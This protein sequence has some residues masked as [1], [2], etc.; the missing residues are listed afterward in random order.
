M[1]LS[2]NI[3]SGV[4]I[5][6]LDTPFRAGDR[7]DTLSDFHK[8]PNPYIGQIV[9]V[10]SEEKYYIITELGSKKV[11][12]ITFPDSIATSWT[13]VDLSGQTRSVSYA[14]VTKKPDTDGLVDFG[15]PAK[16]LVYKGQYEDRIYVGKDSY[17]SP[18]AA[19]EYLVQSYGSHIENTETP[20]GCTR[21]YITESYSQTTEMQYVGVGDNSGW[22]VTGSGISEIPEEYLDITTSPVYLGS[23]GE[24]LPS[25]NLQTDDTLEPVYDRVTTDFIPLGRY[26]SYWYSLYT[27]SSLY[28]VVIYDRDKN[29]VTN[30]KGDSSGIALK[31][32]H[33]TF[34]QQ[35]L[36]LLPERF[37]YVRFSWYQYKDLNTP[38]EHSIKLYTRSNLMGH[39][40]K[41]KESQRILSEIS[42]SHIDPE[43]ALWDT[44][45]LSPAAWKTTSD[46]PLIDKKAPYLVKATAG[47]V[48][49]VGQ[50]QKN[51]WF[52]YSDG[53][54]APTWITESPGSSWETEDLGYDIVVGWNEPLWYIGGVVGDS[55]K[56]I[57][58]FFGEPT[59]YDGVNTRKLPSSGISASAGLEIS[60]VLRS[61][62]F[63]S[64]ITGTSGGESGIAVYNS[65]GELVSQYKAPGSGSGVYWKLGGARADFDTEILGKNSSTSSVTPCSPVLM[66]TWMAHLYAAY[67]KYGTKGLGELFGTGNTGY[68]LS[69]STWGTRTGTR[70]RVSGEKDWTYTGNTFKEQYYYYPT[71]DSGSLEKVKSVAE[72]FTGSGYFRTLGCEQQMALSWA[73][74]NNIQSGV[75]F[76]FQG[77]TFW[78]KDI[79][80]Y[81]SLLEGPEMSAKL[82]KRYNSGAC[83]LLD[84]TGSE[85]ELEI[86]VVLEYPVVC[87]E[88]LGNG[89]APKYITGMEA[90]VEMSSIP[91]VSGSVYTNPASVYL[92]HTQEDLVIPGSYGSMTAGTKYEF[93]G[94]Y[95]KLGD[96]VFSGNAPTKT[97]LPYTCYQEE[98]GIS[99]TLSECTMFYAYCP[100][101]DTYGWGSSSAEIGTRKS[102]YP[103]IG[104]GGLGDTASWGTVDLRY[105]GSTTPEACAYFQVKFPDTKD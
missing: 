90:V 4:Q 6:S 20:L 66:T 48:Q 101:G 54:Y 24:E 68:E 3:S 31:T 10:L 21:R 19:Q 81:P 65:A 97:S 32:D 82:F 12:G 29:Y 16:D 70:Y 7:V 100:P 75:E 44:T 26:D 35:S 27:T 71:A 93:E 49:V 60:G 51:N 77:Y 63:D 53:T 56:R 40:D 33:E 38:L 99:G 39:Y 50:L 88:L 91:A 47:S 46:T 2:I 13:E 104:A 84:A 1:A 43:V 80:G 94:T 25:T 18:E 78:Y 41:Y 45:S 102:A 30:R 74:E 9:Y 14:G 59:V 8:I 103:L 55:G 86:E 79:S 96:V 69:D 83:T 22:V 73:V 105:S 95:E 67:V 76:E 5:D 37:K 98:A 52:R 23:T 72:V 36:G 85:V 34:G 87:G 17:S 57:Y 61:A 15:T 11:S 62:F 64:T 92:C 28:Q 89:P 58:G 42:D